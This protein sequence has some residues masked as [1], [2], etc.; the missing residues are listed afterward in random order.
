MVAPLH[1]PLLTFVQPESVEIES[2][3]NPGLIETAVDRAATS[4]VLNA[5]KVANETKQA[6]NVTNA[7]SQNLNI[8]AAENGTAVA[9]EATQLPDRSVKSKQIDPWLVKTGD[10]WD[11]VSPTS[12]TT[13]TPSLTSAINGILPSFPPYNPNYHGWQNGHGLVQQRPGGSWSQQPAPWVQPPLPDYSL[14]RDVDL[15]LNRDGKDSVAVNHVPAPSDYKTD[16]TDDSGHAVVVTGSKMTHK[17]VAHASHKSDSKLNNLLRGLNVPLSDR[18][19]SEP[20]SVDSLSQLQRLQQTKSQLKD[21]EI[22]NM[23]D[24]TQTIIVL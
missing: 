6:A 22:K 14:N 8:A 2:K 4:A 23:P 16:Y 10:P 5:T 9:N 12:T 15:S 7:K 18:V 13:P 21:W 24:G 20:L 11:M 1:H 17:I 3:E 19:V